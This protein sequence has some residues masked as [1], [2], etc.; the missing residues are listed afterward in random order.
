[1]GEEPDESITGYAYAVHPL[2]PS[3]SCPGIT[4]TPR[5]PANVSVTR[6]LLFAVVFALHLTTDNSFPLMTNVKDT[7]S[8]RK[9]LEIRGKGRFS[10]VTLYLSSELKKRQNLVGG[11]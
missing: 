9:K 11:N 2:H 7:R 10:S 6:I 5:H 8:T 4:A 1:M 3:S